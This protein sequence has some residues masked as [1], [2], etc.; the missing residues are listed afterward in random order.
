MNE[1]VTGRPGDPSGSS[2]YDVSNGPRGGVVP[3]FMSRISWGGVFAGVFVAIAVQLALYSISIWGNFG[4]AKLTSISALQTAATQ[5]AVWIGVSALISLFV[6]GIVATRLSGV[7]GVRNALW[8]S[9]VVWGF[10]AAAM[11]VLSVIGIPGLLGFGLDSASAARVITGATGAA[12]G[13]TRASSAV[14]KYS[15]YYLLF[16]AGGLV[17]AL[18]GGW[19]GQMGMSRR[20][21]PAMAITGSQPQTQAEEQRRAA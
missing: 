5:T 16:T 2:L 10:G 21:A 6:G 7:G 3:S 4:P 14:A 19:V 17:T 11:T 12:T 9:L 18:V 1:Q 13:L 8:H 15:G 20:Q